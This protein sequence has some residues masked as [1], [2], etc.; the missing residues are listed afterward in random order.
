MFVPAVWVC[1]RSPEHGAAPLPHTDRHGWNIH[2]IP[3]LPALAITSQ[4]HF[5]HPCHS[6]GTE[7]HLGTAAAIPA[8]CGS[9]LGVLPSGRQR[10]AGPTGASALLGRK[11]AASFPAWNH[12]R[13]TT[14]GA[15]LCRH[16]P[17]KSAC[18]RIEREIKG[19]SELVF[20]AQQRE[21]MFYSARSSCTT[22]SRNSAC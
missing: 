19:F 11:T 8:P 18:A 9:P 1:K 17:K 4:L 2:P 7:E 21:R 13:G 14:S 15:P 5:H 22:W 6:P 3:E 10:G 16:L 12:L 20:G